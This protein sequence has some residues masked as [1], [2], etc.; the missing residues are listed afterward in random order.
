MIFLE[1]LFKFNYRLLIIR[2][3]ES[4]VRHKDFR[5]FGAMNP[6]SDIGKRN[7]PV[8]IRNRFTEIFVNEID[9]EEDLIIVNQH[10][11]TCIEKVWWSKNA[12]FM[13]PELKEIYNNSDSTSA[14]N[15]SVNIASTTNQLTTSNLL[16]LPQPHQ[17]GNYSSISTTAAV[18]IYAFG[19]VALEVRF[20]YFFLFFVDLSYCFS[21]LV[22][23]FFV[24]FYFYILRK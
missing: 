12:H 11:K 21:L 14:S 13:S 3:N 4:L 23:I 8:N 19:M 7:L 2:S 20:Y 24:Q 16:H 1:N 17:T 6:A 5:L 10:V 15:L 22:H 18:D 9:T